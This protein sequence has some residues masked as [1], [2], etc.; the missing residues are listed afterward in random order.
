MLLQAR[1]LPEIAEL[2]RRRNA[3]AAAEVAPDLAGVVPWP[4]EAARLLV[5]ATA[6]AALQELEAGRRLPRLRSALL[7]MVPD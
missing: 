5:A 1:S 3:Q 2:V 4:R 6:E 7:A